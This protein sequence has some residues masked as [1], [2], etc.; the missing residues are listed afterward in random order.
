MDSFKSEALLWFERFFLAN[1]CYFPKLYKSHKSQTLSS[2]PQ[3]LPGTSKIHLTAII[4]AWDE[5]MLP[6]FHQFMFALKQDRKNFQ[7]TKFKKKLNVKALKVSGHYQHLSYH[8]C[9][10]KKN[11]LFICNTI[12]EI[13]KSFKVFCLAKKFLGACKIRK[14]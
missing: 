12:R 3:Y 6:F 13:K 1:I 11:N 7:A 9:H 2:S 10:K 8:Q 14:Y 4:T 5:F